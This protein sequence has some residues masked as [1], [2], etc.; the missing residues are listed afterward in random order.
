MWQHRKWMISERLT[1]GVACAVIQLQRDRTHHA[2]LSF[3]RESHASVLFFRFVLCKSIYL[4]NCLWSFAFC[5]VQMSAYT[6]RVYWMN[7]IICMCHTKHYT[8]KKQNTYLLAK[9]RIFAQTDY[10]DY[11]WTQIVS[12]SKNSWLQK[13]KLHTI[14]KC[15]K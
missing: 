2:T 15:F 12:W 5:V 14:S 13:W 4:K 1:R 7:R 3:P 6:R 8:Q 10:F 11:C 9:N